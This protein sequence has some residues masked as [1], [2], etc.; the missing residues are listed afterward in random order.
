[1]QVI[2]N[3]FL[4]TRTEQI[5]DN[6]TNRMTNLLATHNFN[7]FDDKTSLESE[8]AD[9][10]AKQLDQ[11]ITDQGRASIAVSGGSTPKALFAQ[12]CQKAIDWEKVDVTLVDERWVATD[13]D[14]SN[15]KMLHA[16][17]LSDRAAKANFI[18]MKSSCED[19]NDGVIHYNQQ[20]QE[21]IKQPFDIVILGMG[22]DGHT[23]SWFPDA[24]E[25]DDALDPNNA[26]DTLAT[27]P[28]SQPMP[29][30][31]LSFA[32]VAKTKSIYLHITGSTKKQVLEASDAQLPI[33]RTLSQLSQAVDIYWAE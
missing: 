15:E 33:H 18:G 14:Q 13:S 24:P 6:R 12:L 31:T 2:L 26:S 30:I 29:R 1:M 4:Q 22:P 16:T 11:S 32:C 7:A 27:H 20:L 25:I 8:L 23:A 21:S 3:A 17:L 10:I 19:V 5:H 9:A 28:E